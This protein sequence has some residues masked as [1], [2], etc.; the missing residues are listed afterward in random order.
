MARGEFDRDMDS[1]LRKPRRLEA[2][3]PKPLPVEPVDIPVEQEEPAEQKAGFFSRIGSMFSRNPEPEEL[4]LE[5]YE[6]EYDP[7]KECRDDIKKLGQ[8]S[9]SILKE[10][11]GKKLKE[12]KESNEYQDLREILGRHKLIKSHPEP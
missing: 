4:G 5:E 9:I 7:H 6:Q 3:Q 11:S 1:Y 2:E 12:F 10:L 8:L